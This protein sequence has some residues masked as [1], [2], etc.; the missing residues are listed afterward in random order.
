MLADTGALA[1]LPRREMLAGYGEVV[2]YGLLGDAGFY[3]WLEE[4]AAARLL[5]HEPEALTRA[6]ARSRA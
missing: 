1:S 6:V 2:K 4:G 3:D 5:A